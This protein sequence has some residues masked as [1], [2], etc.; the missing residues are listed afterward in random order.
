[1]RRR[2]A[3]SAM[4]IIGRIRTFQIV[5]CLAV[6]AMAVTAVLGARGAH[7]YVDRVQLSRQ[8]VDEMTRLAVRANR[9]SEQIAELLL[10][11]E[12]ERLDFVSAREQVVE[13]FDVLRQITAKEDDL[14]T[15]PDNPAEEEEEVQ[16]IDQMF[17]LFREIDQ[18]VGRVLLLDQQDRRDEAIAL[19][20]SDIENRLDADLQVLI[21]EGVEDER[22]D[23]SDAETTAKQTLR[24]LMIG[25]LALV[26]LLLAIV[27]AA[28]MLFARS[29]RAPIASLVEGTQ[30]I[31]RGDLGHRIAYA[32]R[33][34]F[35]RQRHPPAP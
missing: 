22:E 20:R 24:A 12:P 15:D 29:L 4:S 26:G 32:T 30:A 1:M 34:G 10:I 9:F 25:A 21:A 13:Q 18:T 16:R 8:Q 5:L 33:H 7:F 3:A 31:A 11:G 35:S 14:F 19:F 6:L 28:G 17:A 2:R 27:L 23:V